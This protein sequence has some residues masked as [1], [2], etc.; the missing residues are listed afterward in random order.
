MNVCRIHA[1]VVAIRFYCVEILLKFARVRSFKI[2]FENSLKSKKRKRFLNRKSFLGRLPRASPTRLLPLP[3][4]SR[5]GPRPSLPRAG[6]QAEPACRAHRAASPPPTSLPS[7]PGFE[8]SRPPARA[9]GSPSSS[10][11]HRTPT[12]PIA[13][14]VSN[15]SLPVL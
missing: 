12:P 2:P 13:A 6:P 14:T 1:V 15:R 10:S 11:R 8:P 3:L 7:G 4:P 9:A 5:R